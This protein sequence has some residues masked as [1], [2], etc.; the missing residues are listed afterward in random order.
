MSLA[1]AAAAL[2]AARGAAGVA[3]VSKIDTLKGEKEENTAGEREKSKRG[4]P[5]GSK[6]ANKTLRTGVLACNKSK[7]MHAHHTHVTHPYMYA[8]KRVYTNIF[9]SKYSSNEHT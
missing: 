7:N 1:E 8:C 4:R 2:N 6:N 5:A 3:T 9:A